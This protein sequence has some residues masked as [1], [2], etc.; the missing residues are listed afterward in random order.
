MIETQIIK[1]G[2]TP[3]AAIID[4]QKYLELL[5]YEQETKD[6]KIAEKAFNKSKTFHSLEEVLEKNGLK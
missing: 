4:Y 1:Q 2:D 3:I 6:V 5:E